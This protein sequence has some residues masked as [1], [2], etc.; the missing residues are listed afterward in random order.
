MKIVECTFAIG[1]FAAAA[2]AKLQIT[3][4]N[5]HTQW[6]AGSLQTV[7]WKPIDGNLRGRVSIELMEGSDATNMGTVTTIA[8]NIPASDMEHHWNVPK[9]LKNSSNYSIKIVDDGGEEYYGQYF[10]GSVSKPDTGRKGEQVKEVNNPPK[11]TADNSSDKDNQ[12]QQQ[13]ESKKESKPLKSGGPTDSAGGGGSKSGSKGSS[14]Q[15][16]GTGKSSNGTSK[17]NGG[18][19]AGY[20]AIAAAAVVCGTLAM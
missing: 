7:K 18:V 12:K 4:P 20:I 1:V 2:L 11:N 14:S 15:P 8:E 9:G 3:L 17:N 16:S 13:V 10:K 6:E 19:A 5:S